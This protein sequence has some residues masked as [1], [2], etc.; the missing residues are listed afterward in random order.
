M[1]SLINLT[2]KPG[3]AYNGYMDHEEKDERIFKVGFRVQAIIGD[4]PVMAAGVQGTIV[5]VSP[6]AVAVNWDTFKNRES[7]FNY[8]LFWIKKPQNGHLYNLF[9]QRWSVQ[10]LIILPQSIADQTLNKLIYG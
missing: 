5:N 7:V 1:V 3:R 2:F 6:R 9:V 8:N 10:N 4:G